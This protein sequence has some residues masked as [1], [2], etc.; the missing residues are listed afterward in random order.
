L[1]AR[2]K[3]GTMKQLHRSRSAQRGVTLIGLMMWAVVVGFIGYVL[4]RAVPTLLEYRAIV[5][6]V[7]RIASAPP[8]TV[9]GIRSAFDR[10][11]DIE[12]SI[13]TISGKDLDI[14]KENDRVVISFAYQKEVELIAPVFLLIKYE[15]RSK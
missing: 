14:S 4:I 8:P 3:I 13:E 6:A 11:R 2:G 5:G 15:G 9:A 12:Y 10:Q 7:N 1:N